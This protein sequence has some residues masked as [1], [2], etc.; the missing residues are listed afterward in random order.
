V[1]ISGDPARDPRG[2]VVSIIYEVTVPDDAVPKGGDDASH[3]KFY[4]ID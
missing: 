4:P 3:A 2:H 1:T